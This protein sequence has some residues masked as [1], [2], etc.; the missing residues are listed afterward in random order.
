[1]SE[2]GDGMKN[3]RIEKTSLGT[4]DSGLF[5]FWLHL[6]YGGLHQ[7]FGGIGLDSP[8]K[9]REVGARRIPS[10]YGM[11][12][13]VRILEVVGVENW[14]DLPGKYVRAVVKNDRVVELV[15]ILDDSKLF[16]PAVLYRD[17]YKDTGN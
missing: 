11:D 13:I 7:A 17:E 4:G 6:D 14:E 2:W 1:M 9:E 12:C 8:P 10:A 16:N 15:N 5:M 3:A